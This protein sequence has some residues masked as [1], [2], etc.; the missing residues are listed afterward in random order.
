MT[1]LSE[2]QL[3][4][5]ASP[6]TLWSH[7]DLAGFCARDP[8]E[9]LLPLSSRSSLNLRIRQQPVRVE[10]SLTKR[11]MLKEGGKEWDEAPRGSGDKK[12]TR[13]Q[14]LNLFGGTR[15]TIWDPP[16]PP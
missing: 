13:T 4:E 3:K 15:I 2:K 9:R 12:N 14:G 10:A 8:K 6:T 11:G 16:F 5:S 7:L 1:L